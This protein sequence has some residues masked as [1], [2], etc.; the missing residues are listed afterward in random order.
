MPSTIDIDTQIKD[1][2]SKLITMQREVNMMEGMLS[3]FF[4]FKKAGLTKI[5]LPDQGLETINEDST[6]EKPE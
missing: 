4:Q 6:Q 2:Q 5:D 3:L 1:L